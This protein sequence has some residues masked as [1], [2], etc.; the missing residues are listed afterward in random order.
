VLHIA[1]VWRF[2]ELCAAELPR[3][4]HGGEAGLATLDALELAA[5]I[6]R[7]TGGRHVVMP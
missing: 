3:P 1:G 2:L 5:V 4:E 6:R 7:A